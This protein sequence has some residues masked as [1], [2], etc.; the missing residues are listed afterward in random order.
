[1][2]QENIVV[3]VKTLDSQNHDFNVS[4]DVSGRISANL[5]AFQK[6]F[7]SFLD[8]ICSLQ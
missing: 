5:L 8:S 4:S 6:I 2:E 3:T 1:M 7:S